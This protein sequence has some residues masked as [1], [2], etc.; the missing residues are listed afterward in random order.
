MTLAWLGVGGW[1]RFAVRR[2]LNIEH[3]SPILN[4]HKEAVL[5]ATGRKGVGWILGELKVTRALL[6][7][8]RSS[9]KTLRFGLLSRAVDMFVLPLRGFIKMGYY[10]SRHGIDQVFLW[11][12]NVWVG[13]R[14]LPSGRRIA[15]RTNGKFSWLFPVCRLMRCTFCLHGF[16]PFYFHVERRTT[17]VMIFVFR[18]H[19]ALRFCRGTTC[20]FWVRF[21]VDFL[22]EKYP[23]FFS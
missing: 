1:D 17:V 10:H 7:F 18:F 5:E 11:M 16:V 4:T 6:G 12:R 14:T 2:R 22:Q 19:R 3:I 9:R 20:M 15:P 23:R 13:A 21:R 8:C